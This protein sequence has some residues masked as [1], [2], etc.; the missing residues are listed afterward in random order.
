MSK[1]R[2]I[3]ALIGASTMLAAPALQ[4]MHAE[5]AQAEIVVREAES[6][7]K[8]A[9][10]DGEFSFNQDVLT[11]ADEVFNL[12]GTA[13]TGICAKPG[14]A[15][16]KVEQEDCYLNIRGTIKKVSTIYLS[17]LMDDIK[18]SNTKTIACSCGMS[19]AIANA[20]VKGVL[21]K[22]ILPLGELMEGTNTV[23]LRDKHGYGL[24]LPLSYVLEKEAMLVWNVSGEKLSSENGGPLQLWVPDTVA[25][26]FTRQV[27]DIEFSA[28]DEVPEVQNA[29]ESQRAKVSITNRMKEGQSFSVGDQICFEGYADDFG[30]A[31]S[32]IEFS[33]DGGE[34]WTVC[35]TPNTTSERWVYWHFGYTCAAEGNYQ[36]TVRARTSGGDV[37]PIAAIVGFTVRK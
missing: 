6:F 3:G 28:E 7:E 4:A 16:D 27:M 37:S 12:F 22:D 5:Q 36:L 20:Q 35:Q 11:P 9:N 32:A 10:V 34:T 14:F 2:K 21:L 15:F 8:V 31:I 30:Q 1:K 26:Y 19:A 17:E 23:T 24:P 29:D 25:K 18:K 13:A 33:M